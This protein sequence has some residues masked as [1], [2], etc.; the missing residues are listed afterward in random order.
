MLPFHAGCAFP[1]S[2]DSVSAAP[3]VDLFAPKSATAID[4][5]IGESFFVE[6]EEH[7]FCVAKGANLGV[8][9]V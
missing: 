5:F 4:C 6:F 3:V 9:A 8:A 2:F 1:I 7:L